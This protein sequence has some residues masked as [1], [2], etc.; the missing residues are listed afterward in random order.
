[1]SSILEDLRKAKMMN[2]TSQLPFSNA[3]AASDISKDFIAKYKAKQFAGQDDSLLKELRE[4]NMAR[5]KKN[6]DFD[7]SLAQSD[8]SRRFN[9]ERKAKEPIEQCPQERPCGVINRLNKA[10]FQTD[11]KIHFDNSLA[12]SAI[13]RD[14]IAKYKNE[15]AQADNTCPNVLDELRKKSIE[16]TKAQMDFDNSLAQSDISRRFNAARKALEDIEQN[17]DKRPAGVLERLKK[18]EW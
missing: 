12:T 10:A 2:V 5:T 7:N 6:L 9:A 13:S 15:V 14:Y 11:S 17:P 3:N 16:R 1:M 18:A 8:I 4:K